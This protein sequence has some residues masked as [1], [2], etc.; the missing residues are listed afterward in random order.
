[1]RKKI[2]YEKPQMMR[3]EIR[4]RYGCDGCKRDKSTE[5]FIG[6]MGTVLWICGLCQKEL[7][8]PKSKSIRRIQHNTVYTAKKE[9]VKVEGKNKES[10]LDKLIKPAIERKKNKVLSELVVSEKELNLIKKINGLEKDKIFWIGESEKWANE[11]EEFASKIF[12]SKPEEMLFVVLVKE[13]IKC[14]TDIKYSYALTNL[15]EKLERK[16]S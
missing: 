10:P 4:K 14:T 5:K 7:K 16:K 13:E 9:M 15:L 12:L 1:M 6:Y 3:G 11:A 8:N 2:G